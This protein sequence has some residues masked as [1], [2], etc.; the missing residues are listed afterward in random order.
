[1][2]NATLFIIVVIAALVIVG[3]IVAVLVRRGSRRGRLRRT[4]GPEYD[5]VLEAAGGDRVAAETALH[6]RL[7]RVKAYRLHGL[8]GGEKR[9]YMDAWVKLQAAFVNDPQSAVR[10]ADKLVEDILQARGYPLT[11]FEQQAEDLSV[12]H[13]TVVE[14]YRAAHA[15]TVLE[16]EGAAATEDL[17][18]A[19]IHHRALFE[20][21]VGA[22]P[23]VVAAH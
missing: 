17:R 10:A 21:L 6:R 14:D 13:P 5:R 23:Q 1:M 2:D 18:Q 12:A 3:I 16:R 15:I 9:R 19:L 4:F 7:A 11:G 8:S 20:A 22:S